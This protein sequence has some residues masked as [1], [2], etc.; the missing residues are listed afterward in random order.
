VNAEEGADVTISA[1]SE[2]AGRASAT[3]RLA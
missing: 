3:V 1:V 2:R